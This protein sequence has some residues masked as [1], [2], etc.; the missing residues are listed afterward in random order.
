[1][2]WLPLLPLDSR[3]DKLDSDRQLREG[4]QNLLSVHPQVLDVLTRKPIDEAAK[5]LT[6]GRDSFRNSEV[7]EVAKAIPLWPMRYEI[8]RLKTLRGVGDDV[9]GKLLCPPSHDWND[10]S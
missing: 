8:P 9:C 3:S 7:H 10:P 6:Q 1:V 4:Y 5:L 2:S